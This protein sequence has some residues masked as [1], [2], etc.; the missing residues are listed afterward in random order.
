MEIDPSSLDQNYMYNILKFVIY[1]Y[2]YT[3]DLKML[4]GFPAKYI[5]LVNRVIF[6]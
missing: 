6:F 1:F 5:V 2:T 4:D 3:F